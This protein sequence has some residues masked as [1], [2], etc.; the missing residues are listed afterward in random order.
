MA[1]NNLRRT[2]WNLLFLVIGILGIQLFSYLFYYFV[3]KPSNN[4]YSDVGV[5]ANMFDGFGTLVIDLVLI[6]IFIIYWSIKV[7]KDIISFRK[8]RIY[9]YIN[10]VILLLPF[11]PVIYWSL[12]KFNSERIGYFHRKDIVIK[13]AQY[14]TIKYP[15]ASTCV[16]FEE[17]KENLKLYTLNPNKKP[18]YISTK[19]LIINPNSP[20]ERQLYF[21]SLDVY[22]LGDYHLNLLSNPTLDTCSNAL[23]LLI[24]KTNLPNRDCNVYHGDIE[25]R[26]LIVAN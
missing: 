20:L 17:T 7:I 10:I 8:N 25:N 16:A 9:F 2:L 24:L 1:N 21:H 26:K 5:P 6:A 13:I 23:N 14:E 4:G 11:I 19:R 3:E 18:N 15:E 22:I 12:T